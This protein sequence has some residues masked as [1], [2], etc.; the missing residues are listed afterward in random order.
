MKKTIW[1]FPLTITDFQEI[2]MP[3]TAEIL[4][5]QLQDGKPCIW[6]L[7]YPEAKKDIRTF[8]TYGTGHDFPPHTEI[9]QTYIGTYQLPGL[10]YHLFETDL[11]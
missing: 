11:S 9:K 3:S 1:K 5:V 7:V 6:A 8:A 4:C 10:V 2:E